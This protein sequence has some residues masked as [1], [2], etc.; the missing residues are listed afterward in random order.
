[1][2]YQS[3]QVPVGISETNTVDRLLG[4]GVD[5]TA[6]VISIADNGAG[7]N[8]KVMVQGDVETDPSQNTGAT[9]KVY[10]CSAASTLMDNKIQSAIVTDSTSEISSDRKTY[11]CKAINT[12][13]AGAGGGPTVVSDPDASKTSQTAVYSC[14]ASQALKSACVQAGDVVAS[15]NETAS[16]TKVYSCSS[17]NTL[18]LW[19]QGSTG[20]IKPKA[21]DVGLE[22][23][24]A[25][26]YTT[27]VFH[28][29]IAVGSTVLS[30][31]SG[32]LSSSKDIQAPAFYESS[33]TRLKENIRTV[34]D[35]TMA[36]VASVPFV[37]FDWKSDGTH[38]YG[39]IAQDVETMFPE[40]VSKGEE[41]LKAVN[42]IAFLCLKVS[43]LERK[44]NEM[45]RK[46]G[47][48]NS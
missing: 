44:M 30:E 7:G 18:N 4:I 13:I 46:Y 9:A 38:S 32:R 36:K 15:G 14:S 10:S 11:S 45:E 6:K 31:Q 34:S 22:I 33:D 42:Y 8:Y 17:V 39:V 24:D 12:L 1:M 28:G 43:S 47:K 16:D 21:N 29:S 37:E 26:T 25:E 40:L 41:G 19:S 3:A 5:G 20:H 23:G 2:I 35:E 27:S 48:D